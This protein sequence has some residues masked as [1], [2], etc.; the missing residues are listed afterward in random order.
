MH[1]G[2]PDNIAGNEGIDTLIG[3]AGNDTINGGGQADIIYPDNTPPLTAATAPDVPV[4]VAALTAEDATALLQAARLAWERSGLVTAEQLAMTRDVTVAV[5]DLPA[6]MLGNAVGAMI[7]LDADAAGHGWF[8]DQTPA[9]SEEFARDGS[10]RAGSGAD[11]RIDLL[12]VIVHE[13]GHVMGFDD[14]EAGL[15]AMGAMLDV[16]QRLDLG[17]AVATSDV[18]RSRP[19]VQHFADNLGDFVDPAWAAALRGQLPHGVPFGAIG[20]AN[21]AKGA[22][23]AVDWSRAW[24]AAR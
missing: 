2:Q 7:L 4:Q 1:N 15:A 12:S 10:A 3:G 19:V 23:G 22:G 18:A 24:T 16:G 6:L 14:D 9:H 5:A 21:L 8:V 20:A 17:L 13:L 11:G